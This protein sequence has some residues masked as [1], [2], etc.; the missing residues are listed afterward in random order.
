[1]NKLKGFMERVGFNSQIIVITYIFN[2]CLNSPNP[3][4]NI[5]DNLV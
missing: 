4:Q 2:A 5:L 3:F 1:M